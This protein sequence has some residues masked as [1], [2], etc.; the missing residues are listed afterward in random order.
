MDKKQR[1]YLVT[2][3]LSLL[4][5]QWLKRRRIS[6]NS[7]ILNTMFWETLLSKLTDSL[8]TNCFPSRKIE[9]VSLALTEFGSRLRKSIENESEFW[10]CLDDVYA[11]LDN[12]IDPESRFD[13]SIT[14]YVDT[15]WE[16]LD[17]G[18]RPSRID[19]KPPIRFQDLIDDQV[20]ACI[21]QFNKFNSKKRDA[22]L[23]VVDDGVFKGETMIKVLN[24]FNTHK[25]EV[26]KMYFGISKRDGYKEVCEWHGT[27][28]DGRP[29][30]PTGSLACDRPYV[31][32]WVCERDFFPGVPLAGRVVGE[33]VKRELRPLVVRTGELQIPIRAQYLQ[34]WGHVTKWASLETNL[35][36]FTLD[37]LNLSIEMWKKIEEATKMRLKLRDLST[38]PQKVLSDSLIPVNQLL[39]ENWVEVLEVQRDR[40][41]RRLQGVPEN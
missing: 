35:N 13:L 27:R 3:D 15:D 38:I 4:I 14:R 22:K 23:V 6:Y 40:I 28:K 33:Y 1:D 36:K 7:D 5:P 26:N 17:L 32:D 30:Q 25:K 20:V 21:A 31:Y 2:E 16:D 37:A 34:D 9:V 18:P 24:A 41:S 19:E 29:Y 8:Q 39:E 11:T 10:V 12:D